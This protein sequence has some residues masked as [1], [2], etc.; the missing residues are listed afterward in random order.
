[1]YNTFYIENNAKIRYNFRI[2]VKYFKNYDKYFHKMSIY[3]VKQFKK[4]Y[5]KDGLNIPG[6]FF[7]MKFSRK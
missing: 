2:V 3:Y 6:N 5:V 1:M 7:L 4:L